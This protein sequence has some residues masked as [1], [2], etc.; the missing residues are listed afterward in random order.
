MSFLLIGI[1]LWG[2]I[3]ASVILFIWG[4]WKKAWKSFLMSGLAFIIPS[5]IFFMA[6]GW[7]RLL[8]I[9]PLISFA[10]AYYTHNKGYD[11]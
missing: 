8:V 1:T 7:L 4:V 3:V 2:L 5:I 11:R 6:Q 10:L 9:V